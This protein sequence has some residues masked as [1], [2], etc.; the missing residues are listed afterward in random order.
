MNRRSV[1]FV[2]FDVLKYALR[3]AN[4]DNLKTEQLT[5]TRRSCFD[6]LKAKT[7]KIEN[8]LGVPSGALEVFKIGLFLLSIFERFA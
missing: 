1:T 2:C 7:E 5:L 3:Y 8:S 4:H 6:L